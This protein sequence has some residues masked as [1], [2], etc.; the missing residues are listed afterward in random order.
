MKDQTLPNLICVGA[1][2]AGSSSLYKLLKSHPEIYLSDKKEIHYFNVEEEYKK[3]LD[4]YASFFKDNKNKKNIGECTPDY[5][6]YLFVPK[7]IL[8]DLGKIKI[9]IILRNPVDRS[10]SQFNFHKMLNLEK[11]QTDFETCLKAEKENFEI[12]ERIEWYK[13]AFYKS[14][15]LY[16]NQVKR[17]Y[18]TFGKENVHI[19]IFEEMVKDRNNPN[20]K[21]TCKFLSVSENHT[22]TNDHSNPTVMNFESNYVKSLRK[23]KNMASKILPK[24]IINPIKD[25][26]IKKVYKS[27]D[28][29]NLELKKELFNTYFSKDVEKL[30]E[31]TQLDLSIWK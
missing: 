29:L 2:K 30:E 7:R 20:L 10:Y 12:N 21:S 11:K 4:Y 18:D 23:I 6:Q 15:S 26:T 14:K 17:Y 9:L 1:Q 27:P 8:K 24:S 13:P 3:G 19:I 16:Y 5:L 31:L 25:Y 22:F 28:K